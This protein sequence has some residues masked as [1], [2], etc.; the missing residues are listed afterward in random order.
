MSTQE[1]T[2]KV[3]NIKTLQTMID[4]L[5]AEMETIKSALLSQYGNADLKEHWKYYEDLYG[6]QQDYSERSQKEAEEAAEASKKAA[7]DAV[8]K[9]LADRQ[10]EWENIDRLNTLGLMSDEDAIKAR[11]D[12]VKKILRQC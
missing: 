8:A 1:I 2:S 6:Y 9:E 4:E 10:A 3:E 5:T 11:A 7:E 12:F